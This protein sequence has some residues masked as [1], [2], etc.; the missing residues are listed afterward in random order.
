M[1]ETERPVRIRLGAYDLLGDGTLLPIS[2]GRH[3]MILVRDGERIVAAERACPHEGA[4]L[5]LGRCA[6]GRLF[7]PRHLASFDLQDGSV[8]PGWPV[9]ALRVHAVEA[10]PDGL[11]LE[12]A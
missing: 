6:G 10:A 11:W 9:R 12:L 3:H 2:V 8:S 5:S 7:C 1:A 4:D